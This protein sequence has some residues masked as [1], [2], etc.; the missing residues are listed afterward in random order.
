[1]PKNAELTKRILEEA[2]YTEYSIHPGGGKMYSHLRQY[3]WSNNIKKEVA[4]YVD[5]CLIYQMVK[6]GH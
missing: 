2:H 1:M 6:A 3:Y 5:K 4:E